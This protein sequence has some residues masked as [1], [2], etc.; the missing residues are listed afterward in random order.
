MKRHSVLGI[1]LIELMVV[2]AIVAILGALAVPSYRQYVVRANRT[3]AINELLNIAACQERIYQKLNVYDANRC[4]VGGTTTNNLYTMSMTTS[5][6]NQNF[7]VTATPSGSQASDACGNLTYSDQG[8]KNISASDDADKIAT[9][10][11]GGKI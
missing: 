9:C 7:V 3:E 1:T 5:N 10:W 4:G 11:K 2:I 8:V 6:A